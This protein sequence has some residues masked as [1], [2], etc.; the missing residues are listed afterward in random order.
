MDRVRFYRVTNKSRRADASG[1]R[2]GVTAFRHGSNDPPPSRPS[3]RREGLGTPPARAAV[4]GAGGAPPSLPAPECE[5]RTTGLGN[6]GV[7]EVH[8]EGERRRW[9]GVSSC[10]GAGGRVWLE[11]RPIN[12]KAPHP[13]RQSPPQKVQ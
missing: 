13:R 6:P 10:H 4:A 11:P 12:P 8:R 5:A 9:W 3:P 1:L 7:D 2:E